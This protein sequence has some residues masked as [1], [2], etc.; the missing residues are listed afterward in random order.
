[1][2]KETKATSDEWW[3]FSSHHGWVVLDR[4]IATNRPESLGDLVFLRCR[5]WA[6]YEEDRNNWDPPTYTFSDRYLE[7]LSRADALE[8]KK[9][10]VRFQDKYKANKDEYYASVVQE[11]HKNFFK[12]RGGIAPETRQAQNKS[13]AS[14]CWNCKKSVNNSVD[15]E[16]LACGWIVCGSCGACGFRCEQAGFSDRT[17]DPSDEPTKH[18]EPKLASQNNVFKSFREAADYASAH[19]ELTLSRT[20]N[21]NAWK[22]E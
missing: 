4:R 12:A 11:Q 14:V 7:T 8:A 10:L 19:Q 5:D 15:L 17:Y 22:V 2:T 20:N 21:G 1:M 3:G 6:Q 18:E 9:V 13:R 16:C